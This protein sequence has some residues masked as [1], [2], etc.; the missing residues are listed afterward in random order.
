LESVVGIDR[1]ES[2]VNPDPDSFYGTYCR[3]KRGV[4]EAVK[5]G[6]WESWTI[7]RVIHLMTNWLQPI[8]GF[9]FPELI[10]ESVLVTSFTP[11]A[12]LPVFDPEDMG[13]FVLAAFSDPGKFG[14]KGIDLAAESLSIEEIA[15]LLEKVSGKRVHFRF[16]TDEE[17]AAQKAVN[18][19]SD[20]Q[21]FSEKAD[22]WLDIDAAKRWGIPL[23]TFEDFLV[24]KKGALIA[25]IG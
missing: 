1:Y 6:P 5:I 3:N 13:G 7:F 11:N 12:R 8:A 22:T 23:T 14:G 9:Q 10:T 17:V 16:R 19:I 4:E 18:P 25:T 24:K 15:K 2:L 21:R 20:S